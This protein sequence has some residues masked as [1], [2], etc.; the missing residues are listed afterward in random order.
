MSRRVSSALAEHIEEQQPADPLPCQ[1]GGLSE[2]STYCFQQI[3]LA[4][5]RP[6]DHTAAGDHVV[7]A[8]GGAPNVGGRLT[9]E[10]AGFIVSCKLTAGSR[11]GLLISFG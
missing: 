3:V 6:A 8:R 10:A 1:V 11:Y 7:D 2:Q 4:A 5:G 9:Q